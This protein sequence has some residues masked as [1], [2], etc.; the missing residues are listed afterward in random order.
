VKAHIQARRNQAFTLIE[1]LVVISII[2]LLIAILLPALQGA[3]D[4][5]RMVAS[6]SNM[7]QAGLAIEIYGGDHKERLPPL[8]VPVTATRPASNL[9]YF[10]TGVAVARRTMADLLIEDRYL[11]SPDVF[12]SP[13]V[14]MQEDA[15]HYM[16][17]T[18]QGNG[19]YVS[20]H[21]EM[22][23]IANPGANH[24]MGNGTKN[25]HTSSWR[26]EAIT[27]PNEGMLLTEVSGPHF[28]FYATIFNVSPIHLETNVNAYFYDG[29]TESVNTNEF[30]IHQ[31]PV[32]GNDIGNPSAH[33]RPYAPYFP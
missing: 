2:A 10:N 17:A 16:H 3:R 12:A 26:D 29:H 24:P 9:E 31:W 5:A 28:Q 15:P 11:S 21:P 22:Y 32:Y 18:V 19:Q 33:Y 13:G 4:S 6:L 14:E 20:S 23:D 25:W 7:R 8:F 30:P 1:L 27:R